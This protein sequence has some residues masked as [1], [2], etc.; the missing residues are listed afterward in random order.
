[1]TAPL[2]VVSNR[3]PVAFHFDENGEPVA[4]RAG[5]GLVSTLGGGVRGDDVVWIAATMSDAD[6]AASK[7]AD[8]EGELRSDGYR[9]RLVDVAAET[10]AAAY[11][12]VANETLWFWHHHMFDSAHRP[13]LDSTFR[14]AWESFRDLNRALAT[15]AANAAEPNATVLVHDYQMAL[16][17]AMVRELRP[18]VR[19][20]HFTHTPW[21]DPA[22]LGLLPD[23]IVDELL[24]GMGGADACGF[25]APRWASAFEG[26]WRA[27]PATRAVPM[28]RTF[29]AP[30]AADHDEVA[31]VAASPECAREMTIFR[32]SVGDRKCIVRV[33]RIE[34]SKNL[35]RGLW[36]YRELLSSHPEWRNRVCL[37]AMCYPSR[38]SLAEYQQLHH[39]VVEAADSLNRE[40]GTDEWAP[41]FLDTN[42]DFA[43]SVAGLRSADVFLVNPIRDGLNLVAYEGTAI[44][45]RDAAL[46]L[47]RE[48]GAWDEL[49]PAGAIVVNPFDVVSTAEALHQALSLDPQERHERYEKLYAVATARTPAEWL[50]KQIDAAR[51]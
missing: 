15:A 49:G 45:E 38:E 7:N 25:H 34:P 22:L 9:V 30:A 43:R 20:A 1:M 47:S 13:R 18:D 46:V 36:A 50:Q 17:P 19:I 5:G 3:G 6:R 12:V 33:D 11:N 44:N 16:V 14:A 42:D 4:G 35:L 21:V 37:V 28:P 27:H 29:V 32:A 24:L 8:P 39:D 40:F 23:D 26:C 48:A 41:V 10:Y 51:A 31:N 2:I